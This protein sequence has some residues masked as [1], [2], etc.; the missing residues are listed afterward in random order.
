MSRRTLLNALVAPA[1]LNSAQL[2][3]QT[4]DLVFSA[5]V[6]QDPGEDGYIYLRAK[7]AGGVVE[8]ITIAGRPGAPIFEWLRGKAG[9]HIDG[10]L[11]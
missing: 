7:S 5:E 8:D 10:A 11:V 1:V 2:T 3:T 6:A 9:A 4:G